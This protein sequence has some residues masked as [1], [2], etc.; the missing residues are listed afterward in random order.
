MDH[1]TTNSLRPSVRTLEKI[2]TIIENVLEYSQE[3]IRAFLL[4][5]PGEEASIFDKIY[6]YLDSFDVATELREA[7][8]RGMYL[9]SR[10]E[11]SDF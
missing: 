8:V 10:L 9:G 1:S 3:E 2:T 7:E 4:H 6:Q 11:T 5:V